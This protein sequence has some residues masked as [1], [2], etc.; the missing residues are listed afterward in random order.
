MGCF[1]AATPKRHTV[2]SND[3]FIKKLVEQ[4]G[5]LSKKQRLEN[6]KGEP[7]VDRYVD[8]RGLKRVKGNKNLRG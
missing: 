2:W 1:G 5:Y 7:L 3:D 4:G 6:C 8:K